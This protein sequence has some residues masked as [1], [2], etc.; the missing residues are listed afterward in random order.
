MG[1]LYSDGFS[2]HIDTRSRGLPI[3]GHMQ[4]FLNYD[5]LS[6][7]EGC[8]ILILANSADP[9]ENAAFHQGLHC[10]PKYPFRGFQNTTYRVIKLDN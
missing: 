8:F 2:I 9:D 1:P 6:V 4:N 3:V 10:L 7:P 5:G